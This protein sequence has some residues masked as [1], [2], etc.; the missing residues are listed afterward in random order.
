MPDEAPPNSKIILS[1]PQMDVL[2]LIQTKFDVHIREHLNYQN[3]VKFISLQRKGLIELKSRSC[4][5]SCGCPGWVFTSLGTQ[6]FQFNVERREKI[7][8]KRVKES[9]ASSAAAR[10]A[11]SA[12]QMKNYFANISRVRL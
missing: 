2:Y 6:A 10:E 5:R 8:I 3:D 1:S 11:E 9:E 12:E 4:N 7:R